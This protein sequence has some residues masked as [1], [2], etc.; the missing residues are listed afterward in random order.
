MRVWHQI[1][2]CKENRKVHIKQKTK[3]TNEEL[4]QFAQH[5]KGK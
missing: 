4:A 2:K 1:Y 3:K 5:I